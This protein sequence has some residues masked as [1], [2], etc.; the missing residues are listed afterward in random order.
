MNQEV[1]NNILTKYLSSFPLD[2]KNYVY[3]KSLD[4]K[5]IVTNLIPY[6]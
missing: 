5:L 6:S 4:G 3:L 2:L 1:S